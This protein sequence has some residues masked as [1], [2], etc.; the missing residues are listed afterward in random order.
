VNSGV[1]IVTQILHGLVVA[2][3]LLLAATLHFR[4]TG[5]YRDPKGIGGIASLISESDYI[6]YGALNIFRQPPLFAYSKIVKGALRGLR[7]RLQYVA[8]QNGSAELVYQLTTTTDPGYV[9]P[10]RAEDRMLY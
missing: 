7:F 1:A 5:L 6:E 4:Q 2:G 9:V 8:R 10:Q 3:A